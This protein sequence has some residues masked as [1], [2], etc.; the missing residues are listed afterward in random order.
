M[1]VVTSQ[2][3]YDH[4]GSRLPA[5]EIVN[6]IHVI[7]VP[8]TPDEPRCWAADLIISPSMRLPDGPYAVSCSETIF[9]SP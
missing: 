9:L 2:Q 6:G 8:T 7:R 4:P 3:R 1:Y 5:K